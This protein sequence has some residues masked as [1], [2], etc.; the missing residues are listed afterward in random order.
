MSIQ[1]ALVSLCLIVACLPAR[2]ELLQNPSFEEQGSAAD[3]AAHW[4]RWGQWI[5]REDG[6]VPTH[7]GK[8]LVG[9]HH[10]Q[11]EDASDS[12]IWQ[13]VADVKTGQR[14]K[15]SVFVW[16]DKTDDPARQVELR[17]EATRNGRQL[18]IESAKF[19]PK[20]FPAGQWH[21]FS[22]TGTTPE[23][24]L[25]VLIVVTP[26]ATAPRGGAV[27]FDDASLA[28]EAAGHP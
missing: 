10:W 1:P 15:F 7:S 4:N 14:F 17:L 2:A 25:R 6:W 16:F 19:A 8:C 21:Q 28:V 3:R 24:N 20:D 22:V 11:I 23:D 18:T 12:G 27:K 9:Y 5:N 26:A 13:D